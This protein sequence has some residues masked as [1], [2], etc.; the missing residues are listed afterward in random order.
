VRFRIGF[1]EIES[2]SS[3]SFPFAGVLRKSQMYINF[4]K[5][6]IPLWP[7]AAL[8]LLTLLIVLWRRKQGWGYLLCF[9]F[10][11]VY[12][13]C[14]LDKVFFPIDISGT[15]A[16]VMRNMP[17][18]S[19]INLKPFYFG[20]YGLTGT[21]LAG[22]LNNILLTIPLGF[23]LSYVARV[24]FR[25]FLMISAFVGSG[26]ELLQLVIS[27]LLRYPYR[28]IDIND[29]IMNV[30]GVLIGYAVFRL[31][32]WAYLALVGPE[33][34]DMSGFARFLHDIARGAVSDTDTKTW[35]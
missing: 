23:G 1:F 9:A 15:Y 30:A 14:A 11:G 21:G 29:A 3:L 4:Y 20:T 28:V 13:I 16:N 12:L 8:A 17:I 35:V 31:I 25:D 22:L 34:E 19:N 5:F 33:N 6:G 7:I 2:I 10:F 18:N 26:I 27:L 32:A 24:K